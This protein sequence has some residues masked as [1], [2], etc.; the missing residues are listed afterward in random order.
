MN[1]PS[2]RQYT[3][4]DE[5]VLVEG[6]IVTLGISDFAQSELGELVFESLRDPRPPRVRRA[7]DHDRLDAVG[8]LAVRVIGH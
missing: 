4:H 5:W 7:V 8:I 3:E 1:F 2:D 6:N